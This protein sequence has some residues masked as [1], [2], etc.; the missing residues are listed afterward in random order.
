MMEQQPPLWGAPSESVRS[1]GRREPLGAQRPARLVAGLLQPTARGLFGSPDSVAAS[2]P[3]TT[4]TRTM[5]DLT[6][7]GSET[8][9]R[10]KRS[11][12]FRSRVVS[13]SRESLSSEASDSSEFSDA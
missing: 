3:V 6:G 8:P 11:L 10:K 4:L 12:A 2:S 9:K 13:L 5:N 7:L 1:P